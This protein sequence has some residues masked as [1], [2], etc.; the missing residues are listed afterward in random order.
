[1]QGGLFGHCSWQNRGQ[2]KFL[3]IWSTVDRL[4]LYWLSLQ[5]WVKSEEKGEESHFLIPHRH[6]PG[7]RQSAGYRAGVGLVGE[8]ALLLA[9]FLFTAQP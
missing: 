6:I 3:N 1:M 4:V 7:P 2:N 8:S 9:L 5:A